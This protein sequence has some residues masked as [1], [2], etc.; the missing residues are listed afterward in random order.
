MDIELQAPDHVTADFVG[1]PGQ[2]TF[3]L[4]ASEQ[5]ETVSVLVEKEQVA[6]IAEAL[7]E[8]LVGVGSEPVPAWDVESMRL[9]EPVTPRWRAGSVT[10]GIQPQLGRF[11]I[12][13][14][15]QLAEDEAREPEQ[16]RIWI[17]QE[18]ARVV[19]AHA[20][21]SVAQGRPTCGL[22]GLPIDPQGH[23]CPRLNGNARRL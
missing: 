6:G 12:E 18:Q 2:R 19:A 5:D 17:N 22:C 20:A 11:V 14:T 9:R 8:L 10:V 1:Q 4:Q 7:T 3:F 21:W 16:V 23:L 15:E 13:L